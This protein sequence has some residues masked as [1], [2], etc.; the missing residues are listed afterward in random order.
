MKEAKATQSPKVADKAETPKSRRLEY[1]WPEGKTRDRVVTDLAAEGVCSN[2]AL[3]TRFSDGELGELSLTDMIASLR[4]SGKAVQGNDLSGM[5][6]MLCAQAVSLNAIF[7]ELARRSALNMGSYMDPTEKYMR[8]ALKAQGQCRATLETLAAIKNPPVVFARQANI[9]SG[10]QQ[11]NNGVATDSRSSTRAHAQA[12]GESAIQ[13]NGLLEGT[14]NGGTVLDVGATGATTGSHQ[15]L[16]TLGA[17]HRPT[18]A[19]RQSS[20]VPE[21]P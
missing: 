16:E 3:V 5:E 14:Q 12:C 13:T 20:S 8:L 21:Q 6:Q 2:A 7:C 18:V 1:V 9:T 15:I 17:V 4:T 19:A 11:V 10:P